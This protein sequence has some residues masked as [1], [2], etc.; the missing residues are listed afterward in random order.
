[1]KA[2]FSRMGIRK[3]KA[4]RGFLYHQ[5][6][7]MKP[8]LSLGIALALAAIVPSVDAAPKHQGKAPRAQRAPA[9]AAQRNAGRAQSIARGGGA[10]RQFKAQAIQRQRMPS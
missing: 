1:M 2:D 9:M 7:T 4:A 8:I 3:A 10:P 5:K 6:N